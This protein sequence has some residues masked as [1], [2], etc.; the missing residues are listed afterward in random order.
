ME[1]GG[2]WATIRGNARAEVENWYL[3]CGNRSASV[4]AWYERRWVTD[5]GERRCLDIAGI[6]A[7]RSICLLVE[8]WDGLLVFLFFFGGMDMRGELGMRYFTASLKLLGL[9]I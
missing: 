8:M 2:N 3:S 9:Q 5:L 4:H 6:V 1:E 7:Y